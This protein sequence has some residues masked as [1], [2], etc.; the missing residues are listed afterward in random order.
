MEDKDRTLEDW[1]YKYQDLYQ[2]YQELGF[3][4]NKRNEDYNRVYSTYE[5]LYKHWWF[6]F[7]RP[8]DA[9][10]EK[11]SFMRCV[12]IPRKE[13]SCGRLFISKGE[14]ERSEKHRGHFFGLA[15]ETSIWEYIRMRYLKNV[16]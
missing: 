13:V 9:K 8:L 10:I 12:G 4:Y 15:Q 14:E 6:W 2:K 11:K 16:K 3:Q 1:K 7:I 5:K